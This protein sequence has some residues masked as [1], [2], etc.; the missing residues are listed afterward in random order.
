VIVDKEVFIMSSLSFDDAHAKYGVGQTC[1][2]MWLREYERSVGA[3]APAKPAKQGAVGLF[4]DEQG[5]ADQGA[6]GEGIEA[7]RL[8]KEHAAEGS[9]T[10]KEF[11]SIN[12]RNTK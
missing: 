11:V 6:D 1:L 12:A 4:G 10:E 3:V 9:G 8:K 2:Y 5:R 7:A